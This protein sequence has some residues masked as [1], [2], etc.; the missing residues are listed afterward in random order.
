[1]RAAE[2][3]FAE[4]GIALA[5][6][7]EIT[8]RAGLSKGAF[9]LHFDSKEDAFKEVVES[10]LARCAA[11]FQGPQ[12]IRD[13]ALPRDPEAML[14]YT[15]DRDEQIFDFLWQNRAFIA[16]VESCN[17][18]HR[19]LRDAFLEEM[20]KNTV[21]WCELWQA[22]GLWRRDVDVQVLSTLLVGAYRALVQKMVT[23]QTR[24][25]LRQWVSEAQTLFVRG[26]GTD[27]LVEAMRRPQH[28]RGPRRKPHLGP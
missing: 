12:G 23:M 22:R 13:D 2:E 28:P 5:K 11:I 9:Y 8:R 19:Y 7:E 1:L 17:G 26:L 16:I 3:V 27:P 4:K 18:P 14:K 6:V 20:R 25:P 21:A 10:F 15:L 24:P